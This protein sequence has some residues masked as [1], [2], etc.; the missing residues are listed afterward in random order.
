MGQRTSA[1]R[2]I[3]VKLAM[4]APTVTQPRRPKQGPFSRLKNETVF[5]CC[6]RREV[7]ARSCA[8][9]WI[10]DLASHSARAPS[11]GR[12][13]SFRQHVGNV[14]AP[15][16]QDF[17]TLAD[18]TRSVRAPFGGNL[19]TLTDAIRNVRVLLGRSFSKFANAI[20]NVRAL[21]G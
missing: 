13:A 21:F 4:K 11:P 7:A 8:Q 19:A 17:S 3:R 14:R 1:A 2:T 15:F 16:G 18:G 20:H 10:V 5:H 6:A 12:E 9:V